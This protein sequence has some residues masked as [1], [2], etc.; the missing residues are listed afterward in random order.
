MT[1]RNFSQLKK[2]KFEKSHILLQNAIFTINK[3]GTRVPQAPVSE[4]VGVL[5]SF[6]ES[7]E[8]EHSVKAV[9]DYFNFSATLIDVFNF[10]SSKIGFLLNNFG[11]VDVQQVFNCFV[12]TYNS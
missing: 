1:F 5:I 12:S 9:S 4:K 2:H 7:D 8:T 10:K 6:S 11:T 3:I